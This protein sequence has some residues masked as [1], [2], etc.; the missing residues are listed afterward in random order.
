MVHLSPVIKWSLAS[1]LPVF[2]HADHAVFLGN[3]DRRAHHI[4]ESL[5]RAQQTWLPSLRLGLNF[6]RH[7]SR[8]YK[9]PCTV[10]ASPG[11]I[12]QPGPVSRATG[13][14]TSCQAVV[15]AAT[16][17]ASQ[18][19]TQIHSRLQPPCLKLNFLQV[20]RHFR[21]KCYFKIQ[22]SKTPI[23]VYNYTFVWFFVLYVLFS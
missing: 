5:D 3:D 10:L 15:T 18:V 14:P 6:G 16:D 11:N 8:V 2:G 19:T 7:G 17:A 21:L 9:P 23:T 20:K 12:T 4:L 22:P 1:I 13:L